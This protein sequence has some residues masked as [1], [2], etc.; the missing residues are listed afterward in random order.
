MSARRSTRSGGSS[1][2][3]IHAHL[4]FRAHL[5]PV[6]GEG[7]GRRACEGGSV[8]PGKRGSVDPSSARVRVV[9]GSRDLWRTGATGREVDPGFMV[10]S[11]VSGA[12]G[13]HGDC[14][15]TTLNQDSDVG[16]TPTRGA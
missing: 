3:S 10:N 15:G 6:R 12:S 7:F 2:S 13:S 4:D 5:E 8:A 16:S 9:S 14:S 1:A 11:V